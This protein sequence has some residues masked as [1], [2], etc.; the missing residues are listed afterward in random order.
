MD[1][2]AIIKQIEMRLIEIGMSKAD[3]YAKSGI[4]SA[5]FSQWRNGIY[6]PSRKK[7]DS[8]ARVLGITISCFSGTN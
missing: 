4:S 2:T 1:N 7:L 6:V 5:T 3:F 8:A